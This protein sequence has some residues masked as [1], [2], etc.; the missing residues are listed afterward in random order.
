MNEHIPEQPPVNQEQEDALKETLLSRLPAATTIEELA[1][2][3][4]ESLGF[5]ERTGY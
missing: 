2:I 3:K 5:D 4:N 1:E